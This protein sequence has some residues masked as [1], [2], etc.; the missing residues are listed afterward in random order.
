M[1]SDKPQEAE[2]GGGSERCPTEVDSAGAQSE[3]PFGRARKSI[4]SGY[5]RAV[6]ATIS[7]ERAK[8]PA[9]SLSSIGRVFSARLMEVG[10]LF[11]SH[12]APASCR[13]DETTQRKMLGQHSTESS[14]DCRI[15]RLR[16]SRTFFFPLFNGS[17]RAR[18]YC[19][20][21]R[22]EPADFTEP[23]YREE[24]GLDSADGNAKSRPHVQSPVAC[25]NREQIEMTNA[26]K[27]ATLARIPL[28][29][30]YDRVF[31]YTFSFVKRA[32]LSRTG[33][34]CAIGL[35]IRSIRQ[36]NGRCQK[37]RARGTRGQ[38]Q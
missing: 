20:S 31:S 5:T 30:R 15:N 33:N 2:P 11:Q 16:H 23:V 8:A 27:S 25:N 13:I 22:D 7:G 35:S 36:K 34:S 6:P 3:G 10:A 1:A 37:G 24:S 38:N 29:H 32:I 18:D 19:V 28:Q 21:L 14:E 17:T 26:R 12:P 9:G 4:S